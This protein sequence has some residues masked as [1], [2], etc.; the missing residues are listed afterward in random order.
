MGY[1]ISLLRRP[2]GRTE[3]FDRVGLLYSGAI[4]SFGFDSDPPSL[5]PT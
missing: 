5:L 3:L 1:M 2:G 4:C